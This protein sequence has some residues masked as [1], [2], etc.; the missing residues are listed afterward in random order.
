MISCSACQRETDEAKP[1]CSWCGAVLPLSEVVT[2]PPAKG[3]ATAGRRS[4]DRFAPG[5]VLAERYRIISPLG[6]GGMGEVFRAEDLRL[7][8]QVALKFL[9]RHLV[10]HS[11]RL[12]GFYREVRLARLV[13][14]P[15]VC[16]LFDIGENDGEPFITMEYV[17]GE[18]LAALLRR[19][20]RLPREKAI[21]I[22]RQ[23]CE[24]LAAAHDR[25]VLHRDLKPGNVLLD[26][27]G[28][29]RISDFGIASRAAEQDERADRTLSGTPAYLA[30][31]L[32]A[33]EAASTKSDTY[34]LGLILYELFTGRAPF[35]ASSVSAL[36]DAH[37]HEY[38]AKPSSLVAEIDPVVDRIILRCLEKD[39]RMR[40]QSSLAVAAAL[41]GGNPI[42][43]ALALG[44]FPS[45]GLIAA[46]GAEGTVAPSRAVSAYACFLVGTLIVAGLEART[47]ITG[48]VRFEKPPA[49][50]AERAAEI[51]RRTGHPEERADSA[52]QI[53]GNGEYFNYLRWGGGQATQPRKTP[54]FGY[55][56]GYR[57]SPRL[58]VPQNPAGIASMPNDPPL[59]VPGM[60]H[61]QLDASGRLLSFLAVPADAALLTDASDMDW[62]TFLN[63]SG[64]QQL[65]ITTPSRLP[66]V[67]FDQLVAWTGVYP[68]M[69]N[70]QVSAVAASFRAR[71]VFFQ[72]IG[73]WSRPSSV[74]VP[75]ESMLQASVTFLMIAVLIGGS[76]LAYHNVR[77]GRS[78]RRGALLVA[79]FCGAVTFAA[80]VIG[81]HHV[82]DVAGEWSMFTA[83]AGSAAFWALF[84]WMLY[85][86]LEPFVRRRWP[87]ALVSWTRALAGQFRDPLVGRD[88]LA[89]LIGG[90]VLSLLLRGA[91]IVSEWLDYTTIPLVG[92]GRA[93]LSPAGFVQLAC[94]EAF[95]AV[96][97][98]IGFAFL[99]LLLKVILRRMWLVVA[100]WILI[101]AFPF[102]YEVGMFYVELAF[103]ALSAATM[104]FTFRRHGLL[105][106][107]VMLFT[108]LAQRDLLMSI[109]FS[110]WYAGRSVLSLLAFAL[111][112][113]AAVRVAV[114]RQPILRPSL[115]QG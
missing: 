72:V 94:T 115:F 66:P 45:P 70:V 7:G 54:P 30:P 39:P 79:T 47:M 15:N 112:G 73:P 34:A 3:P 8:Q 36:A 28:Q 69:S 68:E 89:G 29:V 23:L 61:V 42:E 52:Y 1:V 33:G 87:L 67:S 41:P 64:L 99:L 90:T 110:T 18:D 53:T 49:V 58:L 12:E 86:S 59:V 75:R 62:T 25:G 108:L 26:G 91:M 101:G 92:M 111:V 14:H 16:R 88:V 48:R 109:D 57:Q 9:P 19:I 63:D 31:E 106:V 13:S 81:A 35:R 60:T 40:P 93:L 85:V 21:E 27:L 20:G 10:H 100:A 32:Y 5:A 113:I 103:G 84:V 98:S 107:A 4:R 44:D 38:P 37:Q 65:L 80:W 114:G 104:Y 105:A 96:F 82:P 6:H 50:M 55:V 95:R 2:R 43:A 102:I 71:P 11:D 76:V 83:A 78:D 74:P 22:G 56:F 17:D 51:S 97:Y 24:G 46:T 77:A